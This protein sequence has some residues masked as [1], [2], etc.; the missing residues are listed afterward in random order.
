MITAKFGGTAITGE[1]LKYVK[2]FAQ[3]KRCVVV[4]A[5]G[6]ES[7]DSKKVTDLLQAYYKTRSQEIW[8][9][10]C[11]K[12]RRLVEG[13]LI[14]NVDDLLAAARHKIDVADDA[15]CLSVGERLSAKIVAEYL[16]ATYLEAAGLVVFQNG[17]LDVKS[18]LDRIK[19][20]ITGKKQV[21]LGGFYGAERDDV[22]QTRLLGRGG[23]DY[24]GAL[25]AAATNSFYINFT[26]TCGVRTADPHL[27]PK[28]NLLPR[29]S[30]QQMQRLYAAGA[31]VLHCGAVDVAQ[32]FGVPILV[33]SWQGFVEQTVV[34]SVAFD[35]GFWGVAERSTGQTHVCTAFGAD[36]VK[37][38]QTSD[39][40]RILGAQVKV[41]IGLDSV[42]V[43]SDKSVACALHNALCR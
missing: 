12:Y 32:P 13:N 23:G 10:I 41:A 22:R 28:A 38:A 29:L 15:F 6:S 7:V 2:R 14:M 30:Y 24:T 21:V 37:F 42:V 40:Q 9:R 26:D 17:V 33:K 39:L 36:A 27:V 43:R 34:S 1:N 11:A 3:G 35:G 8:D 16:G 31:R 20:A 18:T 25:A 4:S 5:V 19:A